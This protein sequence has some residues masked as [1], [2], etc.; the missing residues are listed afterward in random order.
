MK[1][2]IITLLVTCSLQIAYSQNKSV[3]SHILSFNV[4]EVFFMPPQLNDITSYSLKY[5]HPLSD[6]FRIESSI[7][8]LGG[9]NM[10]KS[11]SL[12]NLAKYKIYNLAEEELRYYKCYRSYYGINIGGSYNFY[13]TPK[14]TF[15]TNLDFSVRKGQETE[16]IH[17]GFCGEAQTT[18]VTQLG[19]GIG[20]QHSWSFLNNGRLYWLNEVAVQQYFNSDVNILVQ[21]GLGIN[22]KK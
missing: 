3:R 7:S 14:H 12:F 1:Q 17:M 13:Q 19:L 10:I 2:F 15:S 5:S 20:L 22:L 11:Q 21:T 16:I 9:L 6:K 4:G 8:L 18:Y